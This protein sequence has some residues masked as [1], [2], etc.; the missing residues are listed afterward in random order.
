[1]GN[2]GVGLG[3]KVTLSN[4]ISG[5]ENSGVSLRAALKS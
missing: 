4:Y 2:V 3:Q 5:R 1:M